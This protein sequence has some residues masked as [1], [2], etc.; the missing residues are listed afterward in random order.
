MTSTIT[1]LFKITNQEGRVF[2][3]MRL[4]TI[5]QDFLHG[6]LPRKEENGW[7]NVEFYFSV[8]LFLDM[9][10]FSE[11]DGEFSRHFW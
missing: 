4:L 1:S 10:I 9:S 6:F 3:S 5:E 7:K 11:F 2:F 8:E